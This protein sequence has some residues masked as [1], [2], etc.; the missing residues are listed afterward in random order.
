[1]IAIKQFEFE[2]EFD[3]TYIYMQNDS[4]F[5]TTLLNDKWQKMA[6]NV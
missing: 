6:A 3:Y 5:Y 2:F 1:M 4:V